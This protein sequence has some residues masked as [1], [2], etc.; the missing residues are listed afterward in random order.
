MKEK[1][2]WIRK[3]W[4]YRE[5]YREGDKKVGKNMIVYTC[6]RGGKISRYGI[7]VS[8]KIGN[9]VFRNRVKRRLKEVVRC[10]LRQNQDIFDRVIVARKAIVHSSY[11]EIL[12][13]CKALIK[14]SKVS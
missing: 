10:H 9:A 4:E 6:D 7:A 12:L 14:R 2:Q 13:E 1:D 8:K 11:R 3:H 5:V